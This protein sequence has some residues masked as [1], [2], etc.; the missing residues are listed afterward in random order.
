MGLPVVV[1]VVPRPRPWEAEPATVEVVGAAGT[2]EVG[3]GV[4]LCG[5][6]ELGM[7]LTGAGVEAR[8]EGAT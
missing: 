3:L 1:L 8:T 2:G 4:E 7:W 5:W 6:L